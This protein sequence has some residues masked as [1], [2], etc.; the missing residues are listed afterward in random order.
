ME[1]KFSKVAKRDF[2]EQMDLIRT[3]CQEHNIQHSLSFDSYYFTIDGKHYRVSNHTIAASDRG[4]FNQ[5]GEQIR[6]SYHDQDIDVT[7]NITASKTRIITIY[8]D[9]LRGLKLD[10]RGR[11][12]NG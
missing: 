7:I 1:Y 11:V 5:N 12:I 4:M 8:S 3:F 10:K 6:D 2:K 9:L